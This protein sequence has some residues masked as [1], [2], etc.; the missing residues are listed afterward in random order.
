MPSYD[1]IRKVPAVLVKLTT[2]FPWLVGN[3]S[4][5]ISNHNIEEL[6][7]DLT[8]DSNLFETEFASFYSG[9][10]QWIC[11][12][13]DNVARGVYLA[14]PFNGNSEELI[15]SAHNFM[16]GLSSY[17][18]TLNARA[19]ALQCDPN[20]FNEHTQIIDALLVR[21]ETRLKQLSDMTSCVWR[22][23]SAPS[24]FFSWRYFLSCRII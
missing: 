1:H 5:N 15:D 4:T 24:S 2:F 14:Q 8:Y 17:V 23:K 18:R 11:S 22:E 7:Y 20:Q 16:K 6:Q 3:Y 19:Q 13:Q 10:Q 21:F 12:I 9:Y